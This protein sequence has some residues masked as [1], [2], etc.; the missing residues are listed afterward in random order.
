MTLSSGQVAASVIPILAAPILGRLY[1]PADYGMLAIYMALANLIG[2][3]ST[4]QLQLGIL[5]EQSEQR[6]EQLVHVCLNSSRLVAILC[7]AV[8]AVIFVS[9]DSNL[10]HSNAQLWMLMLPLT[11][12]ATGANVGI[13]A[14]ANRR[15]SYGHMAYLNIYQV[16][17][18]TTAT[19]LLGFLGLGV[20]GLF[21][22]YFAGHAI[23]VAAHLA[24]WRRLDPRGTPPSAARQLA[25][26]RRHRKF[27]LY[28]LPSG[29]ISIARMQ[30]P[31]LVLSSIGAISLL[32][33][34]ARANAF[35]SMPMTLLGQAA[36]TVF[37]QRAAQEFR[38]T[39]TCRR[40]YVQTFT[41]LL[42]LGIPPT[43]VLLIYGP[44]LFRII[45]GPNWSEAGEV[46]RILAP[47]LLVRLVTSPLATVFYFTEE[48]VRELTLSILANSLLA[49][50]VLGVAAAG[51]EGM[52][53]I[54]TYA[55]ASVG[56][57]AAYCVV[58]WRIART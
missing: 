11:I 16:T 27:A 46:A 47:M 30:L 49:I 43:L 10:D 51:G 12:L 28:S 21:I 5:A 13:I 22:G 38:A 6:A 7:L 1:I 32:G 40:L 18:S 2:A 53:I 36:A 45:L 37:R 58:G 41:G 15:A 57:Y 20:H 8:T 50:T 56:V 54:Y 3:A 17:I 33:A 44:E 52:T 9:M 48:Q 42:A 19:V 26:V 39:G 25:L 14:L 35:V 23:S 4:L 24:L 29:F 55:T 34:Y 31:A